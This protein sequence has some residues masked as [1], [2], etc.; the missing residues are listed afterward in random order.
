[1]LKG[2]KKYEEGHPKAYRNWEKKH[3]QGFRVPSAGQSLWE[4]REGTLKDP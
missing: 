2:E 3:R 4:T 1:M